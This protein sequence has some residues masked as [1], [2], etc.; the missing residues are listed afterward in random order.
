MTRKDIIEATKNCVA[1]IALIVL[2]LLAAPVIHSTYRLA[3]L[4]INWSGALWDGYEPT[5]IVTVI[6]KVK[7][8]SC[9]SESVARRKQTTNTYSILKG[10]INQ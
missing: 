10:W 7:C 6:T 4:S 3:C 9:F 1:A 8:D 5:Q 2:L